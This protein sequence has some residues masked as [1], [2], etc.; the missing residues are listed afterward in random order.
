MCSLNEKNE[1]VKGKITE[2]FYDK[3]F[4]VSCGD[5]MILVKN[6]SIEPGT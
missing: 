5:G 1:D 3:T 4:L 6:Y 2:I